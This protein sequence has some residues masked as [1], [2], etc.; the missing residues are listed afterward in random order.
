MSTLLRSAKQTKRNDVIFMG[1]YLRL[2]FCYRTSLGLSRL[3]VTVGGMRCAIY[4]FYRLNKRDVVS[5]ELANE[6]LLMKNVDLFFSVAR[7]IWIM[8]LVARLRTEEIIIKLGQS[9]GSLILYNIIGSL[10]ENTLDVLY[11]RRVF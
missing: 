9:E 7:V 11:V 10:M 6:S 3:Y 8:W 1:G 4:I 2:L 5:S